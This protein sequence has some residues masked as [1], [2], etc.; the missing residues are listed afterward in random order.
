M[1][2]DQKLA[3]IA[4]DFRL[5]NRGVALALACADV[6]L[7]E[8]DRHKP[9]EYAGIKNRI[10]EKRKA[11]MH[12]ELS[13]EEYIL[14]VRSALYQAG[15][16]D[17]EACEGA[18]RLQK[19]VDFG[20]KYTGVQ[21]GLNPCRGLTIPDQPREN[22]VLARYNDKPVP[23]PICKKQVATLWKKAM[24]SDS[25]SAVALVPHRCYDCCGRYGTYKFDENELAQIDELEGMLL[26]EDPR[27]A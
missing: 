22:G 20:L 10:A 3:T 4:A 21:P 25:E 9:T 13:V 16:C 5:H 24:L 15:I 17:C 18:K 11:V 26:L 8:I 12:R 27:D 23:C 14:F 1:T 6:I 7:L 2:Q 19:A